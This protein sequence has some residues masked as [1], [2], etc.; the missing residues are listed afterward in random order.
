MKR[1][2]RERWKRLQGKAGPRKPVFID[3]IWMKTSMSPSY[4]LSPK[5]HRVRGSAPFGHRNTANI[6]R[7]SAA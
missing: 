4:G 6:H 1:R 3:E 7:R 5:G 2:R